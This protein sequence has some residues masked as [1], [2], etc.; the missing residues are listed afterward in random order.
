MN[1]HFAADLRRE[2]LLQPFLD[3]CYGKY[4]IQTKRCPDEVHQR[5]G[6]D[7]YL[8][9]GGFTYGVDEKAQLHYIGESLP[10]FALEVDLLKDGVPSQGWLF[11]P[12]KSTEV[13]AFVFDIRLHGGK[14][15]LLRKTQVS[16]ARII[17][18]NRKRLIASLADAGL[19]QAMLQRLSME[20]RSSADQRRTVRA[21]GNAV[22]ISRQF[23]EQPV[24]LLVKRSFLLSIGQTIV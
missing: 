10:T 16:S 21:P 20:L 15:E 5:E 12:T 2:Q 9:K 23:K 17:L 3:R 1:T 11:D 7:V 24:N 8:S 22:V 14:T 18:V 6:I 13:Y 4:G 19:D